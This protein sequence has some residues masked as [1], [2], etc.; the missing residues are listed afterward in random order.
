MFR[1]RLLWITRCLLF[2]LAGMFIAGRVSAL[3]NPL[4]WWSLH[5]SGTT[6]LQLSSFVAAY[7]LPL[8]GIYGFCL[9]LIPIHRLK[10]LIASSFGKVGFRSTPRPELA[11]SRPLLWAWAPVGLVLA[12]RFLTFSTT[13][14]RS[15]LFSPTHGESR[16][17]HFFASLNL[18]SESDLSAWI[19]DRFV[20]TGPTLFLLAYTVGVWLRHQLPEPPSSPAEAP[21]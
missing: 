15:A 5:Q 10:E 14:D 18:R 19:F 16:Y 7:Y 9:G 12:I 1:K 8:V 6:F 13:A 4:I 21:E 2:C 3:L 11:F 17:E 20:L